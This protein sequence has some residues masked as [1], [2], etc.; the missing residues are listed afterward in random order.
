MAVEDSHV[1]SGV[2]ILRRWNRDVNVKLQ[3][4]ANQK[5]METFCC[6]K[7]QMNDRLG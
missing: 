5:A 2:Q 1:I 7:R 6:V 3:P 4:S